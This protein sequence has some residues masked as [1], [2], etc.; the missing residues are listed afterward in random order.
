[1]GG[2]VEPSGNSYKTSKGVASLSS[3]RCNRQMDWTRNRQ[4]GDETMKEERESWTGLL[5]YTHP[6]QIE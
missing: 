2:S 6:L 1:M 3:A 4:D 5:E